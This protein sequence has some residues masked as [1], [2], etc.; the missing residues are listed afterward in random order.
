MLD[1][2]LKDNV[3][4]SQIAQQKWSEFINNLVHQ[5]DTWSRQKCYFKSWRL[6]LGKRFYKNLLSTKF[7]EFDIIQHPVSV[8][9]QLFSLKSFA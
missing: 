7:M 9:I 5:T 6:L 2:E 1:T 4:Q 8:L 3:Q